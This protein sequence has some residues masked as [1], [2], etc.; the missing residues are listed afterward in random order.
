MLIAFVLIAAALYF[1]NRWWNLEATVYAKNV[2]KPLEMN[3]MLVDNN[4]ALD[5][6]LTDPGWLKTR[7]NSDFVLDHN[8]LM[9]LYLLREPGMDVIYHLHPGPTQR[10]RIQAAAAFASGQES[11]P[12]TPT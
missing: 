10:R 2:Y 4:T 7:L 8:H 12:F 9:H 1:A 11:T 6:K 5:L 3:A